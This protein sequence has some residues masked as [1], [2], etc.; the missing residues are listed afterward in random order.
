MMME[1]ALS[2]FQ[3]KVAT[4]ALENLVDLLTDIQDTPG[5]DPEVLAAEMVLNRLNPTEVAAT[6]KGDHVVASCACCQQENKLSK[7]PQSWVDF[8]FQ[9]VRCSDC[10]FSLKVVG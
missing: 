6:D 10:D 8:G 9:V 5:D 3:A 7:R 2:D 1:I 4:R